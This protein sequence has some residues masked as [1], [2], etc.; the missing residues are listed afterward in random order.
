V[1]HAEPGPEPQ[2]APAP[3][4]E[5]EPAPEPAPAPE[6]EPTPEPAAPEPEP[7]EGGTSEALHAAILAASLEEP[8]LLRLIDP[9]G[10]IGT[11]DT[12]ASGS[13]LIQ[14]CDPAEAVNHSGVAF[15]VAEEDRWR[16][17]RD[18]H[19]CQVSSRDGGGYV[20]F[21]RPAGSGDRVWLDAIIHHERTVP[22]RDSAAVRRFVQGGAGV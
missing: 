6:P 8:A 1:A 5:P 14:H 22:N 19:R 21:F 15:N 2:R 13:G 4:P 20:F 18:L 11:Y 12:S 16:C 3:E 7:V 9:V 17:G 10:G